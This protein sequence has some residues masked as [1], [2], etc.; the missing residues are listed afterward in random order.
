[1]LDAFWT[2][3]GEELAKTWVARVLT[4]AFAFWLGGAVLLWW[5]FHAG[6]VRSRGWGGEITSSA[7]TVGGLPVVVQI[8]LIVGGLL[9]VAISALLAERLTIPV[10][11][12]LE[13]YWLRPAWLRGLLVRYRQGRRRR[14]SERVDP[15]LLR[16]RRG[17]LTPQEF[18]RLAELREH[19]V[20]AER[21]ERDA[22]EARAAAGLSPTEEA[23]LG[24]DVAF[25]AT[26]PDAPLVMPTRLGDILRTAERR[27]NEKYGI[28]GVTSWAALTMVMPTEARAEV[29]QART[30]LDTAARSWLWGA[31]VI[32]W[33]PLTP[34]AAAVGIAVSL[35]VYRFGVLP[36]A[37]I[38]GTLLVT[39]FD[40]YRMSLYDA[41]HL[42]RPRSPIDE[43]SVAGPRLTRALLGQLATSPVRYRFGDPGPGTGSSNAARGARRARN[44]R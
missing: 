42:P 22:L 17:D 32:V 4:P 27:P 8:G 36:R 44:R 2:G 5:H 9:V 30:A 28:E 23:R 41:L 25:L 13:G 35:L 26:T 37:V 3:V 20:E 1:M 14:V 7:S 43:R 15:L 12:L 39:A 11:R 34:W 29:A 40:L 6:G 18:R 21:A 16:Q 31:L 33:S 10:L 19:P 24:R 38:F